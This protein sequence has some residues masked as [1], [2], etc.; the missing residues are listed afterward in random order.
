MHILNYEHITHHLPLNAHATFYI[1][2]GRFI[3][4]KSWGL[5]DKDRTGYIKIDG[6][7]IMR[8][9]PHGPN[10]PTHLRRGVFFLFMAL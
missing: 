1:N 6:Q 8:S 2:L 10:N 5:N 3:Q 4:L 7:T 9:S